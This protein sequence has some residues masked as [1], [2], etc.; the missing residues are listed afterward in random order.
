MKKFFLTAL[1]INLPLVAAHADSIRLW[2]AIQI[3]MQMG[4]GKDRIRYNNPERVMQ[5]RSGK[6][7]KDLKACESYLL[8]KTGSNIVEKY[9]SK[10]VWNNYASDNKTIIQQWTCLRVFVSDIYLN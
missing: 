10:F 7:F 9:D 1:L 8:E 4:Q 6:G 3:D 2:V 5:Y